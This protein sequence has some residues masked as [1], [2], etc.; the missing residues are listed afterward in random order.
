MASDSHTGVFPP[1]V[2]LVEDEDSYAD[3][4]GEYL[5]NHGMT[6]TRMSRL[7]HL[8][9][10]V[11]QIAPRVVLLDQFVHG[12][13][14]LVLLPQLRAAFAG[15]IVLLTGNRDQ[16]DR[17]VGLEL[18]AD[19]FIVKTQP[20]REILARLRAVIRRS[21]PTL[22]AEGAATGASGED[23]ARWRIDLERRA[24]YTPAGEQVHLTSTEF[25]L[26]G[27]LS[28]R[29]GRPVS[30][31]DLYTAIL[32]RPPTGPDDR[33]IDNLV[34][35]LRAALAPFMGRHNPIRSMRG[36]GYVFVGLDVAPDPA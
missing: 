1:D 3:E 21:T 12:T 10:E 36:V 28:P 14:A 26:L 17:V 20:P 25:E 16:T 8:C 29:I 6:S 22:A 35:R 32:R 5:Q 7:D 33:A 30:R 24:L 15:G 9:E 11:Q 23:G 31:A 13:D 19:D 18:G 27:Y 2:L 4:L 34:S